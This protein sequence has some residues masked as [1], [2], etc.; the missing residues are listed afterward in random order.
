LYQIQQKSIL[1]FDDAACISKFDRMFYALMTHALTTQRTQK[2]QDSV[3]L[4]VSHVAVLWTCPQQRLDPT[5]SLAYVF[6]ARDEIAPF[7]T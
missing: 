1:I 2:I 6:S 4:T 7:G 3:R 5:S